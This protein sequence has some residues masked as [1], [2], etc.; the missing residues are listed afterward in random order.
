MPNLAQLEAQLSML[1]NMPSGSSIGQVNADKQRL[2]MAIGQARSAEGANQPNAAQGKLDANR[3]QAL[4]WTAGRGDATMNDPRVTAALDLLQKQTGEGP[5]SAGVV[6]QMSNRMADR[7][8]AVASNQAG[9]LRMRPWLQ[10]GASRKP[11]V[12]FPPRVVAA[13]SIR[14]AD[15]LGVLC[16]NLH[17]ALPAQPR[18]LTPA[19]RHLVPGVSAH[20]E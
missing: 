13:A 19:L 11:A 12:F 16:R 6:N 3:K 15:V 10:R 18:A 5:L 17:P 1:N 14:P 8:A 2:A 9:D 20:E 4:D 7:N